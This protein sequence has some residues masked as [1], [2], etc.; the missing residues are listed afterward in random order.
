MQAH[1][2]MTLATLQNPAQFLQK[3][4]ARSSPRTSDVELAVEE[5]K[6]RILERTARGVDFEERAFA[7]YSE[8]GP[9]YYY[10]NGRISKVQGSQQSRAAT[11]KQ[12]AAAAKRFHGKINQGRGTKLG[13]LTPGGGI[14]FAS[15]AEFKRALGRANVDLLGPRAPHML[16]AVIKAV[17]GSMEVVLGVYGDKGAIA[18]GHNKGTKALPQRKWFGISDADRAAIKARLLQAVRGRN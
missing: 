8:K 12:N 11:L 5:Q 16:Q 17:R 15:Y 9:Y 2:G 3:W 7:P 18:A 4:R 10:P 13:Q 14:K 1:V 6:T